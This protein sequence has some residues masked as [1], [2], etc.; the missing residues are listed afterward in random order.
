MFNW[1][2]GQRTGAHF[3]DCPLQQLENWM[4]TN[5]A[6][7][8]INNDV[9]IYLHLQYIWIRL[10]YSCRKMIYVRVFFLG[11]IY[12][13]INS[14]IWFR[15]V[16]SN[17]HFEVLRERYLHIFRLGS[18]LNYLLRKKWTFK[19]P[20]KHWVLVMIPSDQHIVQ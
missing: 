19:F 8:I 3:E 9:I 6:E 17:F 5:R 10:K 14:R 4:N 20:F 12:I 1:S 2:R 13:K 7:M 15:P 18:I 16:N 11:D